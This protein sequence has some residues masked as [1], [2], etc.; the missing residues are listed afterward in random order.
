MNSKDWHLKIISEKYN[1]QWKILISQT[2]C[3]FKTKNNIKF[4]NSSSS[5]MS[6][7]LLFPQST[8]PTLPTSMEP[9][10]KSMLSMGSQY[11]INQCLHTQSSSQDVRLSVHSS[12]WH[13]S[14]TLITCGDAIP[15]PQPAE[16]QETGLEHTSS[17]CQSGSCL[18]CLCSNMISFDCNMQIST[19]RRRNQVETFFF[20]ENFKCPTKSVW[21]NSFYACIS[22]LTKNYFHKSKIHSISF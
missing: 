22:I 2:I 7:L 5:V 10:Q 20:N 9:N 6:S 17:V 15:L 12:G 21:Y 18:S 19:W 8:P 3:H 4:R 16:R 11:L 14:L 13:T 1:Y